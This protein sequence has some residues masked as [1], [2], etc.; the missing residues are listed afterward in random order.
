MATDLANHIRE[1]RLSDTHEHLLE[2]QEWIEQGPDVLQDL[3]GNYVTGDLISAGASPEAVKRLMDATDPD[4]AGRF[5]GIRPAWEATRLTGYGEAVR[6]IASEIYELPEITPE[7]LS[8]GQEKLL[9][10]RTPGE[11]YRL[12][13]DR[14]MLDHVQIDDKRW[15]CVPDASGPEFFL[16]DIS[17][18]FFCIGRIEFDLL[19]EESGVEVKDLKSLGRAMEILFEKNAACA[20][21]VKAQHAYQR[22]LKWVERAD[23]D[24]ERALQSSLISDESLSEADRLC[25]GDWCWA[26]GIELA[27]EYDLPF[28]I[29]TGYYA[30]N[31]RMPVD[32]I[33]SGNLHPILSRYP[34]ARFVL[35]HIAYPYCDELVAMAKHYSNVWVDLCWAWSIDPYSSSDFVRRFIHA[36]PI[37]KLFAFGGD[38]MW[39]TSAAA[40]AIQ[41]RTWMTRTLE[42]EVASGDLSEAQA[43]HVAN[44]LMLEN[45]ADCFDLDGTRR[46][47]QRAV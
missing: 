36:V 16:Y 19:A 9:K 41:A 20:I 21:A 45:Q 11:R 24:A 15:A 25:L 17:W 27:I 40:Y 39:P 5:D 12:L 18:K 2:E 28:K 35:M 30:G 8:L 26:K 1:T 42:R 14:A 6:L 44:R 32:R 47:I 13:H 4:L 7:C 46:A 43:I 22:T 37:T 23:S 10:L 29:H 34:D 38:T 31:G 3:F 33:S